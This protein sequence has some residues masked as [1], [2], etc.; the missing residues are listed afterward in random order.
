MKKLSK[1]K[2]DSLILTS[3][4]TLFFCVFALQFFVAGQ[5]KKIS[6]YRSE[7][8]SIGKKDSK[9]NRL[10]SREALITRDYEQ[11]LSRL[12]LLEEYMAIGD[13]F[14]WII[15]RKEKFDRDHNEVKTSVRAGRIDQ[16]P[17]FPDFQYEV[18][19]F[20]IVGT[21]PFH[22]IGKY[23]SGL[24]NS[25]PLFRIENLTMNEKNGI[26]PVTSDAYNEVL[27]FSFDLLLM[28]KGQES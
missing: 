26:P 7:L 25:N 22:E 5:Q 23:V 21:A 15:S 12:K 14:S 3:I 27:D 17:I 13:P 18:I 8:G 9:L 1:D 6:S 11:S 20:K 19:R 16:H 24:E 4:G 28:I 10:I 2:R